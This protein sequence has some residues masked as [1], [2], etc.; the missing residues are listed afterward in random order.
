MRGRRSGRRVLCV[1]AT[2]VVV[3]LVATAC[4]SASKSSTAKSVGS[5][6]GTGGPTSKS[7]T[8]VTVG[9]APDSASAP[10]YIGIK[11]GFFAQE[12]LKLKL[13]PIQ[14][15]A[16]SIAALVA[17]ANQF[18]QAAYFSA[19][20][21]A[22]A[23][24]PAKIVASSDNES[25][26]LA[27]ASLQVLVVT[28]KSGIT[29]LKQLAG[30][31]IAVTALKS[32]QQIAIGAALKTVGVSPS[33]VKYLVVPWQ[34]MNEA[35][36]RGEVTA[37]DF[38]EPFLTPALEAGDRIIN[39]PLVT[40]AGGAEFPNSGFLASNSYIASHPT[41]VQAFARGMAKS[42]AYAQ[43]HPAAVRSVLVKDAGVSPA[44]ASKVRL[45]NFGAPLNMKLLSASIQDAKA[46]G[47]I[48][49]TP[50]ASTLVYK[51]VSVTQ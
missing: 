6:P 36:S 23:G 48:T 40:L 30:K 51:S 9:L 4:G 34:N 42:A 10:V 50:A 43:Q 25:A 28:K 11:E 49:K 35:L 47:V 14:S 13:A 3:A 2:A 44:V 8:T 39:A 38:G 31:T 41:I 19:I 12:G 45:Q 32:G 17:G 22:A 27:N 1:L 16:A 18:G 37:G 26:T 5:S 46:A 20:A 33:A 24:V 15:G 29:S 7:L 21:A